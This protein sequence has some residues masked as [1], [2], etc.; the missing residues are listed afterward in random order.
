MASPV[1][2]KMDNPI[3][4][5]IIAVAVLLIHMD[6]RAVAIIN[7]KIRREGVSPTINIVRI[8]MRL[9]RFHLSMVMAIIKPPRNRK[10]R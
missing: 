9:C 10:M 4:T 6:N 5:I 8:A 2:F 3:G 1:C 7:P